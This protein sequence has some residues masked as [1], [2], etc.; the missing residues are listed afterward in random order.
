MDESQIVIVLDSLLCLLTLTNR[1]RSKLLIL[2]L[3]TC[4][5]NEILFWIN[6]SGW[7]G[8]ILQL[9]IYFVTFFF[10]SNLFFP[11]LQAFRLEL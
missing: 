7:G 10:Y 1:T 5:I 9:L 11:Q 4:M 8:V 2:G 6:C 3:L